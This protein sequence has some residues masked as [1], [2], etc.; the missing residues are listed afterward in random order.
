MNLSRGKPRRLGKGQ[1]TARMR[2][3]YHGNSSK[4]FA[5]EDFSAS[6]LIILI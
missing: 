2:R 5:R 3:G 4:G 1:K 6:R